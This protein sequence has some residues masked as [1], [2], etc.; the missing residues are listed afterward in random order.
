MARGSVRRHDNGWGYRVDLGPDP[1]TGKRRQVSKQGFRT[2]REAEQAAQAVLKAAAEGAVTSR[3]HR[4]VG[5]YLDEWLQMQQPRLRATTHHSYA[6]AVNRI[7]S[8]LGS[9]KLQSLTPLQVE[10]FYR[11]LT[12]ARLGR[13]YSPK[14]IRNTHTVLRKALAD[15]ERL[16]LV[17]RN[18]A[19]AARPPAVDHKDRVTWSSEELGEFLESVRDDRLYPVFVVL[20]TTGMRRG[21]VLGL[22]W[23]D[24]DFDA[25]DLAIANTRTPVK[26]EIVTGPPKTARS[27][28]QVFLDEWT[29]DVLRAQRR[30]QAADRLA[31]GPAWNA[32]E[33]YVFTDELGVPVNPNSVSK[34]FDTI[35]RKSG[36]PRIRLHD[37]RHTYATVALK[38]GVHPK[39]VS[40]RLGHATVGITLDLYSHVTPSIAR[41]AAD[42]VASK[43]RR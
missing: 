11:E 6:M 41:D 30:S 3:T 9:A 42:V 24:V 17:I 34:R 33:D 21:E 40:E 7:K 1:A 12:S 13:D 20:A 4:T 28:R 31:A 15:A 35:V 19:A 22:R 43:I 23:R 10:R 25:G 38:A 18:A 2:K 32:D 26:S 36:L 37:L 5:E 29:L 8:G 14:T 16:E 39:V 27:R